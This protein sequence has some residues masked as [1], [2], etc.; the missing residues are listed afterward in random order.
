MNRWDSI[1]LKQKILSKIRDEKND[2]Y[3]IN[4]CNN[5]CLEIYRILTNNKDVNDDF[6]F[7]VCF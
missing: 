2:K 7:F 5:Y 1:K 4:N 3:C 6:V